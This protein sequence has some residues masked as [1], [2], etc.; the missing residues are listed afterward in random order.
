[1]EMLTEAEAERRQKEEGRKEEE[2]TSRGGAKHVYLK[3]EYE[4]E[5][6]PWG[7]SVCKEMVE[8]LASFTTDAAESAKNP[9]THRS[10]PMTA[11]QIA[12]EAVQSVEGAASFAEAHPLLFEQMTDPSFVSS[13]EKMGVVLLMLGTRA[14]VEAGSITEAEARA[15]VADHALLVMATQAQRRDGKL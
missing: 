13:P 8:K 6:E 3:A 2:T 1:M 5:E 4:R 11:R 14:D 9:S 15:K 12:E 7:A 10:H